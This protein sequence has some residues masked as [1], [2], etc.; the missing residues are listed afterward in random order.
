MKTLT[1]FAIAAA[2][3]GT[4]AYAQM[5]AG[6]A[7]M[8]MNMPGM[9]HGNMTTQGNAGGMMNHQMMGGGMMGGMSGMSQMMGGMNAQNI[10]RN[11]ITMMIPHH[12]S[13]IDMSRLILKT[14]KDPQV[15]TWATNIIRDQQREINEMQVLLKQFG[16]PAQG[17]GPQMNQMMGDM[18]GP[19]NQASN[20]DRA[21]VE[22]MIPHHGMAVMMAN[23][24]LMQ[25]KN[26]V[27]QKMGR[28]IITAQ[29][30]EIYEFQQYPNK[31]K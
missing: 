29:A 10:D 15:K 8:P 26:P 3:L 28:D 1:P 27:M 21:F 19:I 2:T 14:T 20:K 23:H 22:G 16:G 4:L 30:Q 24:L 6:G 31:S 5:M 11:F 25:S 9:N 7:G 13:A 17:M 18:T 12:Q